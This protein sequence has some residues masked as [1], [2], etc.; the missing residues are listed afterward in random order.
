MTPNTERHRMPHQKD[1]RVNNDQHRP[2]EPRI[3]PSGSG[4]DDGR[5]NNDIKRRPRH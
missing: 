5:G 4:S 2:I 1:N 3:A